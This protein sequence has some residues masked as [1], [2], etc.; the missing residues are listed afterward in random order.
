MAHPNLPHTDRALSVPSCASPDSTCACGPPV[1]CFKPDSIKVNNNTRTQLSPEGERWGKGLSGPRWPGPLPQGT[2]VRW[3]SQGGGE[4]F[5]GRKWYR[6]GRA[7]SQV[8]VGSFRVGK[9]QQGR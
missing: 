4:T 6:P 5:W 9:D 1:L 2:S 3:N 7:A 8:L